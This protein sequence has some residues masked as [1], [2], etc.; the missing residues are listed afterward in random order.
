MV[1]DFSVNAAGAIVVV[2]IGRPA[3]GRHHAHIVGR[4]DGSDW[5]TTEIDRI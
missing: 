2:T 4:L 1:T 5:K 3:V